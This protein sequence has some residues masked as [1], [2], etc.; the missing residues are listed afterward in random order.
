MTE[1]ANLYHVAAC[2][3][4][5]FVRR[6][7]RTPV[8]HGVQ[9]ALVEGHIDRV[10]GDG[11]HITDVC[12]HPSDPVELLCLHET[13]NSWRE[14]HTDLVSVAALEQLLGYVLL[15]N[16]HGQREAVALLL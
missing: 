1:S 9:C 10:A 7:P 12:L 3:L 4:L 13:D 2:V 6:I 15:V 16:G 5:D 14:V 11:R 8:D